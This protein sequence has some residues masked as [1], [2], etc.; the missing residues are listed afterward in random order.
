MSW[1]FGAYECI[2]YAID[3]LV[4]G[5]Y[6]AFQDL[7]IATNLDGIFGRIEVKNL[8]AKAI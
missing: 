2:L 5:L 3:T 8:T 6:P 1:R 7:S 4:Y